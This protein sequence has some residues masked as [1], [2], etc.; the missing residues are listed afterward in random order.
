VT[1]GTGL[2]CIGIIIVVLAVALVIGGL[3][4]GAASVC[5]GDR[6][7]VVAGRVGRWARM[8]GGAEGRAIDGD[9]GRMMEH[10]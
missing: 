1:A 5:E 6:G 2:P 7:L 3:D 8:M 4:E 9:M 10:I